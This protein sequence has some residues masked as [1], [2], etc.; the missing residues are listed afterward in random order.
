MKNIT[1]VTLILY[2]LWF[3]LGAIAIELAVGIYY[4][5]SKNV[6]Q[7]ISAMAI[8]LSAAVASASVMKNIAETKAHD[9]AKI[10]K[11]KERKRIFALNT[12]ETMDSVLSS[13]EDD[14]CNH[15]IDTSLNDEFLPYIETLKKLVDLVFTETII[16]YL[17]DEE[18]KIITQLYRNFYIFYTPY[19]HQDKTQEDFD[20]MKPI[21]RLL[22]LIVDF[23]SIIQNYIEI[24]KGKE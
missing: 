24:S 18:R 8:L 10:E 3:G 9:I 15:R 11:E 4:S 7:L 14:I 23:K 6:G 19:Q 13:L 5:D 17:N 16:Q 12:I 1:I 20:S 22:T 2:V 21:E